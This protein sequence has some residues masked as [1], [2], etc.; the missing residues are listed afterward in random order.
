MTQQHSPE[1]WKFH[2]NNNPEIG[3]TIKNGRGDIA[4]VFI[5]DNFTIGTAEG[6]AAR[7]VV[8]VNACKG[9]SNKELKDGGAVSYKELTA[10]VE[11]LIKPERENE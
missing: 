10:T 11:S 3:P 2:T 7:I 5:G 4:N 1:P 9:I 8:C 6:N